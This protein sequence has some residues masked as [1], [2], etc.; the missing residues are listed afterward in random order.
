MTMDGQLE[1]WNSLP[2]D[3]EFTTDFKLEAFAAHVSREAR[4]LDVGCGYGRL[5][6]GL[7]A[8]GYHNLRGVD[9]SEN[10]LRRG[11]AL[12]PGIK[13][14]LQRPGKLDFPDDSFDAVLLCA[15]LTCIPDDGGQRRL[16]D[17]IFRVLKPGGMLYCNDFLLNCD[18]RNLERY[19]RLEP[20]Y[21]CYGVFELPGGAVVRHHSAEH[22]R[23]LFGHF[24]EAVFEEVEFHTMNNHTS[25]G[26]YSLWAKPI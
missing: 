10:L 25:R 21:G 18:R 23:N 22:I 17:E 12:H 9:V 8:A 2:E 13:M 3:K 6:G 26:F 20:V 11:R 19:H 24:K 7:A 1:Y 16:V 15:V 4:I 5:L 14:E